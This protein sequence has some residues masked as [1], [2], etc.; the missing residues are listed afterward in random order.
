MVETIDEST[1][2]SLATRGSR[3]GADGMKTKLRSAHRAT[4]S[5]TETHIIR[6]KDPEA[7]YKVIRGE[8]A[9]TR[10]IAN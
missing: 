2:S 5:G 4:T 10:F 9:G 3:R 1:F 6:G 7:L 8:P